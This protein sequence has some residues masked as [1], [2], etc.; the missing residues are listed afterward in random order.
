MTDDLR[1]QPVLVAHGTRSARGV[2]TIARLAEQVSARLGPTRTAF[3]DVLGPSPREVLADTEGPAILIPAFLA[4]GY[5][6]RADIP[7]HVAASGHPH[8]HVCDSLGPDPVIAGV[9]ADR[10]LGAGWRPG[11]AVV[12]AAAGSSDA[13]ALADVDLAAAQLGRLLETPVA[14][15]YLATARPAV[16]DVV[17]TVRR[18]TGRRVFIASYLLAPGLF[19]TRLAAVGADG[20]ASPLGADPRIVDL[21]VDRYRVLTSSPCRCEDLVIGG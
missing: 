19:H 13:L 1:F 2:D 11:D 12:L 3:V 20:V 15:G 18:R 14:V 21:V 16:A 4:S 6:V 5:H 10:L 17:A 8:V 9:M 7:A